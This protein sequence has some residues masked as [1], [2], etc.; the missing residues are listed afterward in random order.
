[1]TVAATVAVAVA[2]DRNRNRNSCPPRGNVAPAGRAGHAIVQVW[3]T[4]AAT[5]CAQWR[6]RALHGK[7]A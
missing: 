1:V 2:E 4:G 7:S 5:R 6:C 3:P